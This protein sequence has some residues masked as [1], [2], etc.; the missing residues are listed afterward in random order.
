M[1]LT[2]YDVLHYLHRLRGV[3]STDETGTAG[4]LVRKPEHNRAA[5]QVSSAYT[6]TL[7]YVKETKI[8]IVPECCQN[9]FQIFQIIKSWDL[10]R[11]KG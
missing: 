11:Q 10:I 8:L 1:V 6:E 2:M 7:P 9:Q 5:T 4:L 3:P